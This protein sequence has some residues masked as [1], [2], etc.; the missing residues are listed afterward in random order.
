[1]PQTYIVGRAVRA[2]TRRAGSY[3]ASRRPDPGTSGTG[4]D[5]Q[6]SMVTSLAAAARTHGGRGATGGAAQI[7]GQGR[8]GQSVEGG[9]NRP[10]LANA[11]SRRHNARSSRG[12]RCS[13]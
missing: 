4:G 11:S 8:A 12:V 9:G 5:T 7:G 2:T 1:M 13:A 10:D 6:E 3:N